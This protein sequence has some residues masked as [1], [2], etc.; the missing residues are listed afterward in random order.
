MHESNVI[1]FV[2]DEVSFLIKEYFKV[3]DL[4]ILNKEVVGSNLIR[5]IFFVVIF[6]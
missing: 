4:K 1:V 3:F 2:C 5:F 6:K